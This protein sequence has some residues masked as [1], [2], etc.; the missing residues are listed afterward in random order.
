MVGP[1][2]IML[3]FHSPCGNECVLCPLVGLFFAGVIAWQLQVVDK[4]LGSAVKV[5]SQACQLMQETELKIVDTVVAKCK[6]YDGW[7]SWQ[8][9]SGPVQMRLRKVTFHPQDNPVVG[10]VVPRLQRPIF[11]RAK[12]CDSCQESGVTVPG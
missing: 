2:Q 12:P 6:S 7:F 4:A 10:K 1:S 3:R 9:K 8:A 11:R 5:A